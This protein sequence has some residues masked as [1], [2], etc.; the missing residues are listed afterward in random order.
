MK[1]TLEFLK[2][3]RRINDTFIKKLESVGLKVY[4]GPYLYW[5]GQEYV[6]I[7]RRKVWLVEDECSNYVNSFSCVYRYQNEVIEEIY[8]VINQQK[9][10]A[11][12]SDRIV[13]EF[14]DKL[15]R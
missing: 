11:E 5:E 15:S 12:E 6:E 8:R 1:E 9:K 4:Y 10:L 3:D 2:R 7:G 14:F 13:D